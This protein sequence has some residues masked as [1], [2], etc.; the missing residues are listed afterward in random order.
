MKQHIATLWCEALTN[1]EFKQGYNSLKRRGFFEDDGCT[2]CVLGVLCEL[3]RRET[4]KGFWDT[5]GS[6]EIER[7]Y[8][9][10]SSEP[11]V[12]DLPED[13]KIWAGM[14]FDGGGLIHLNDDLGESFV[15]LAN[16]IKDNWENL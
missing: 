5:E 7:F 16:V 9:S 6:V 15:K 11:R 13:V 12:T 1:G 3:Y 4:G 14:E 8:T 2:F 10:A